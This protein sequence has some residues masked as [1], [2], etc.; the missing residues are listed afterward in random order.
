MVGM[1]RVSQAQAQENRQRVV[2]TASRL[3]RERGVQGVSVTDLMAEAGLTHGGFYKQFASKEALVAETVGTAYEGLAGRLTDYDTEHPG[4]HGQA[5][6]DLLDYYLSAGHRDD[7]GHGCPTT[8]FGPDVARE[9][10]GSPAREPFAAG[11]QGFADWLG[12]TD[13]EN[14]VELSTMVGALLLARAT[15]GTDLSDRIL[16]AARAA[17][18]PPGGRD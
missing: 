8:G 12:G 6:G 4:D 10:P 5:V 7:P 17:L 14:L 13:D 3:F 15:S 1:A 11:V 2:E 18:A 16:T 9:A